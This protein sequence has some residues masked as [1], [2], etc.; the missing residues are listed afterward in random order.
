MSANTE[1]VRTELADILR[2]LEAAENSGD[3]D[4]I[5]SMMARDVAIMVPNE[6]TQE[7]KAACEQFVRRMLAWMKANLDRHI[8]YVSAETCLIGEYAFD[9]GS[10]AFTATTKGLGETANAQG[11]YFWLYS[12]DSGG[13]WKLSRMMVSLDDEPE[14]SC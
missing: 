8:D 5:V 1:T 9:R 12:R 3:A 13:S 14:E 11:K 10:F 7:G 6:P 4:Y 2:R